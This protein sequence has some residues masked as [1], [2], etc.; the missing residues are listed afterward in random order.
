MVQP[1]KDLS[2]TGSELQLVTNARKEEVVVTATRTTPAMA[3]MAIL[4]ATTVIQES[5]LLFSTSTATNPDTVKTVVLP[6]SRMEHI[7]FEPIKRLTSHNHL[8]QATFT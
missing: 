7:V 5:A 8:K 3:A 6:E 4:A 1:G 2:Q